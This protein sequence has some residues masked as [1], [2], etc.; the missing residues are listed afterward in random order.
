MLNKENLGIPDSDLYSIGRFGQLQ[1]SNDV[2][3]YL[4]C[5]H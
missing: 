2:V 3:S 1:L 4:L 5:S